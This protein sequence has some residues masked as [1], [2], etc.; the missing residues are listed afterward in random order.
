[1]KVSNPIAKLGEEKASKYLTNKGYKIIERNFRVGYG[2]ID[3]IAIKNNILIF[4]EVKTRTSIKFGTPVE[5]ITRNKIK[6]LK[7]TC[8]FYKL[9]KPNLPE[10]MRIDA[11][12]VLLKNSGIEIEH[13]EN[14][15]DF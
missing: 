14:I 2:E 3:I 4:V 12:S 1:M 9:L 10:Q 15:I 5:S 11:V 7:K 13:L 8:E 6:S